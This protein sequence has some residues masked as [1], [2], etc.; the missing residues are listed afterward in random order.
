MNRLFLVILIVVILIILCCVCI[1]YKKIEQFVDEPVECPSGPV[2]PQGPKGETGSQGPVGDQGVLGPRGPSGPVGDQGDRGV[3]GEQGTSWKQLLI[4]MYNSL[5]NNADNSAVVRTFVEEHLQEIVESAVS[6][7]VRSIVSSLSIPD[8]TIMP[9]YLQG[10]SLPESISTSWQICNGSALKYKDTTRTVQL[11]EQDVDTPDLRGKFIKGVGSVDAIGDS[12]TG[13]ITLAASN[14]PEVPLTDNSVTNLENVINNSGRN[15][16]TAFNDYKATDDNL[17]SQLQVNANRTCNH[18]R[19][20]SLGSGAHDHT[21]NFFNDDFNE[22]GGYGEACPR[23]GH[24]SCGGPGPGGVWGGWRANGLPVPGFTIDRQ[25]SIVNGK[26]STNIPEPSPFRRTNLKNIWRNTFVTP[27]EGDHTH[28]LNQP[29]DVNNRCI[30]N[31][32]PP[33]LNILGEDVSINNNNNPLQVGNASVDAI[34]LDNNISSYSLV[35]II[36]RP[37]RP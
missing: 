27:G 2:G 37:P 4:N 20:L 22:Y 3:Q 31:F 1:F 12:G 19:D 7:N 33:R 16:A 25:G 26:L 29:T 10:D 23:P 32:D 5:N 18:L 13:R 9:Y 28:T 14:I 24:A 30:N 6:A 8:Y 17:F 15:V 36:K 11:N 35:F 21:I 34:N